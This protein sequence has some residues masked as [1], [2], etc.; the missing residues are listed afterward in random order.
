MSLA[1]H[2]AT[3]AASA[4]KVAALLA[5]VLAGSRALLRR[6]DDRGLFKVQPFPWMPL[7]AGA[8]LEWALLSRP[9]G[10]AAALDP[11]GI[12]TDPAWA[13]DLATI[14]DR[15][16]SPRALAGAAADTAAGLAADPTGGSHAP[17]LAV[18]AAA[19]LATSAMAALAWRS[20]AAWRGLALQLWLTAAAWLVL[21]HAVIL[22]FWTLHWL[23]FWLFFVLLAFVQMRRKEGPAAKT[24]PS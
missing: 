19:T 21:H 11:R 7:T 9:S 14:Y 5:G 3:T 18:L 4:V 1:V 8:A 23:N 22:A 13:V 20:A 16:L 12:W 2:L 24:Y 17:V 15:H 6:L 10:L